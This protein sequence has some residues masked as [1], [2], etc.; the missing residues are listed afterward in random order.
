MKCKCIKLKL[1]FIFV[2]FDNNLQQKILPLKQITGNTAGIR[3]TLSPAVMIKLIWK[4]FSALCN[5]TCF[6]Y[7]FF[8]VQ[9]KRSLQPNYVSKDC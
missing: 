5:L 3:G 4:C 6:H 1:R 8:T 9:D 2:H 7:D